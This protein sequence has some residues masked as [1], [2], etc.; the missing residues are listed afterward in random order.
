MT[1]FYGGAYTIDVDYVYINIGQEA[2]YLLLP[3]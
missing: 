2:F 3:W 1:T